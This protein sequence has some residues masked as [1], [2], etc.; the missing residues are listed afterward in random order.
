MTNYLPGSQRLDLPGGGLGWSRDGTSG[1][2]FSW[3]E[4]DT[5]APG[6]TSPARAARQVVA[7]AS[8]TLASPA[9]PH[10]D[11]QRYRSPTPVLLHT[12]TR[13]CSRSLSQHLG[14]ERLP[15]TTRRSDATSQPAATP[16]AGGRWA[17]PFPA[18]PQTH[19]MEVM[20]RIGR[21]QGPDE[22]TSRPPPCV[23]LAGPLAFLPQ[24]LLSRWVRVPP[25][26]KLQR[27]ISSTPNF[28]AA[29][30][31]QGQGLNAF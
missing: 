22:P 17:T 11:F 8:M 2:S 9:P 6:R 26:R 24:Y 13:P 20:Q 29:G 23:L 1:W 30:L 15:S 3:A 21:E 12:G 10:H 18:L 16:F 14:S 7:E 25:S 31:R 28:S 5:E 4:W 19:K 27:G